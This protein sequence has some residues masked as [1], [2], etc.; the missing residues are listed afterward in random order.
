MRLVGGAAADQLQPLLG[1]AAAR[2]PLLHHLPQPAAGEQAGLDHLGEPARPLAH[3]QRLQQ[4]GIGDAP[5][6]PGGRRRRS[7]WRR[8]GRCRSCRRWRRRPCPPARSAPRSRARRA[9]RWRPRSRPRRWRRRRP[10]PTTTSPRSS[11]RSASRVQA[12]RATATVLA[13]SPAGSRTVTNGSSG[14]PDQPQ[15]VAVGD[16]RDPAGAGQPRQLGQRRRPRQRHQQRLA[17]VQPLGVDQRVGGGVV[18]RPPLL[19]QLARS[20]APRPPAGGRRR[21][22]SI[23]RQ[24][25]CGGHVQQHREA[26]VA[27][28]LAGDRRG[29][30]AAAQR[31]HDVQPLQQPGGDALLER[32]EG[33]LAVLGEDARRSA[34]P[35]RA[36]SRRRRRRTPSPAARPAPRRRWS[37]RRP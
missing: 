24:A 25:V 28:P 16:Q 6:R 32:A 19:V 27:Q 21:R 35:P 4:P 23:R 9:G 14:A 5:T 11:P 36:R 20:R 26:A 3:R 2:L 1:G 15:H 37:C 22:A 13:A 17:A 33:R 31:D 12:W 7:S 8:A 29:D 30:G 34:C 10:A 18:E